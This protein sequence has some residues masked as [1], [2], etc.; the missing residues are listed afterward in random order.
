MAETHPVPLSEHKAEESRHKIIEAAL[1][2]FGEHGY[3]GASTNQICQAAGIS[4]GLLYHYFKSKENLFLAVCSRCVEDLE[5]GYDRADLLE[6]PMDLNAFSQFYKQQAAF[7]STHPNHYHIL[8]YVL[9]NPCESVEEFMADKRREYKD[10]MSIAIR[11][12][13]SRN[14]TRPGVNKELALD[15]ML[16]VIEGILNKYI[17][18]V[19]QQHVSLPLALEMLEQDLRA[20]VDIFLNGILQKGENGEA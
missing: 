1:R 19:Y 3:D 5:S 16:G 6:Q 7:F 10:Q 18:S 11:L 8:S 15:M 17:H 9:E 14:A 20:S 12:F 4:K 13:L 2:E